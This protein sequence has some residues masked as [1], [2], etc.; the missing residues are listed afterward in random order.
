MLEQVSPEAAPFMQLGTQAASR[1]SFDEALDAFSHAIEADPNCTEAY[2][3]RSFAYATRGDFAR[4]IE[5]LDCVIEAELDSAELYQLRAGYQLR[6]LNYSEVILDTTMVIQLGGDEV[7]AYFRRGSAYL[8]A[9]DIERGLTDLREYAKRMG[10]AA[11]PWA[12][13]T[14]T[15]LE[16]GET[17]RIQDPNF[18]K[19]L[20]QGYLHRLNFDQAIEEFNDWIRLQPSGEA[21]TARGGTYALLGR[22][23]EAMEDLIHALTL[24]QTALKHTAS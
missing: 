10:E 4:A 14:I 17:L 5:D 7:D 16:A 9:G 23:D 2:R 22:F 21:Y 13:E 12:V 24:D 20:G 15:E 6:L 8:A 11:T 19:T 3:L 18:Y 1:A